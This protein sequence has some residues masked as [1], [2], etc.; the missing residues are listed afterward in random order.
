LPFIPR[1]R[2]NGQNLAAALRAL[3]GNASLRHAASTLGE[4]IRAETGS[5]NA[6]R[7]IEGTFADLPFYAKIMC[8][9]WG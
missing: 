3:S 6:V 7:L 2:L 8:N 9:E 1:P 4:K 5:A